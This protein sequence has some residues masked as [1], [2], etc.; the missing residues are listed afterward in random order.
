MSMKLAGKLTDPRARLIHVVFHRLAQ[1]LQRLLAELRQL[2]EEEHSPMRK[3]DLA[4]ARLSPATDEAGLRDGVMRRPEGTLRHQRHLARQQ[5]RHAV[6]ACDHQ[7]FF[8][9]HRRQDG[10]QRAR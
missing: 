3:A 2:I 1:H 5:S 7:R 10:R 8:R 9:G 4:G 6:D